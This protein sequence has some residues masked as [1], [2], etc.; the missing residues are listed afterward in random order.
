MFAMTGRMLRIFGLLAALYGVS[1]G[2]AAPLGDKKPLSQG[3]G[4]D[5]GVL[6]LQTSSPGKPGA[7]KAIKQVAYDSPLPS[8]NDSIESRYPSPDPR[9]AKEKLE[10]EGSWGWFSTKKIRD[11]YDKLTGTFPNHEIARKTFGD[12]EE[13]FRQAK[14]SEAMGKYQDAAKKWHD[15]LLEE[16]AMFYAAECAYQQEHY[17]NA[18]D[19]YGELLKKYGNSRH[20]DKIVHRLFFIA[21]TWEKMREEHPHWAYTP[22]WFWLDKRRP[23]IDPRGYAIST[24]DQIRLKDPTGPLADDAVM[25]EANV[26]FILGR[27]EDADYYYTLLRKDFPKSEHQVPAHLLGLQSKL[28]KYQGPDYDSTPLKESNELIDQMLKQFPRELAGERDHLLAAR[29]TVRG[30]LADRD[31]QRAEYYAKGGYNGA[32]K[33]YYNQI[34]KDYPQ[35]NYAKQAEEKLAS[36]KGRPDY[37]DDRFSLVTQFFEDKNSPNS[38]AARAALAKQQADAANVQTASKPG[39]TV[40]K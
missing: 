23:L 13:L 14:Y 8:S 22:N 7:D 37:P 30:M 38:A 2:C 26:Y 20:L 6:N 40:Q 5:A 31:W 19:M 27:Y 39:D 16:D 24:W 15:S 1:G 28:R 25:A 21:Q 9:W 17:N 3:S 32:A 36:L 33:I 34:V 4:G 35:S 11:S 12:A 18:A 29:T 10:E